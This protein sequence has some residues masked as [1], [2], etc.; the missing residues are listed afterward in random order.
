MERVTGDAGVAGVVRR[1]PL[2]VAGV[3]LLVLFFALISTTKS[4]N[5]FFKR[6]RK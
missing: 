5:V 2:A 1:Q 4:S 3:A 6:R